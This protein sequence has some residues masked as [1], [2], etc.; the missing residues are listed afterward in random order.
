MGLTLLKRMKSRKPYARQRTYL[1]AFNGSSGMTA[2]DIC[3]T[4][5]AQSVSISIFCRMPVLAVLNIGN[6]PLNILASFG[7]RETNSLHMQKNGLRQLFACPLRN[8]EAKEVSKYETI[9]PKKIVMKDSGCIKQFE[10]W[11]QE[12]WCIEGDGEETYLNFYIPTVFDV[13]KAF[14]LHVN[15]DENDDYIN[16]YLNWYPYADRVELVVCYMAPDADEAYSVEM[17]DEQ[18]AELKAVLPEIC[19]AAYGATPCELWSKENEH[20]SE[21]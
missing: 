14:G 8:K 21:V 5:T 18:I 7:E 12:E 19:K 9:L 10:M 16:V 2:P 1:K 11:R 6:L 20:L 3:N 13:D 17:D 4:R 15:T